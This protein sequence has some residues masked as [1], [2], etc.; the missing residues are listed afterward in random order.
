MLS[1]ESL[2]DGMLRECDICNHLFTKF[3]A[4]GFDY[5]PSPGQRDTRELLQYLSIIGIAATRCMHERNWKLFGEFST[6]SETMPPDDF[7]AAMDRQKAELA[8]FFD[9]VTEEELE[10]RLAPMPGGGE[11]PLGV[12]ILNGPFKW[13]AAYKLQLFLYAKGAGDETIGTVNAWA[14]VDM[15]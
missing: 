15:R 14:G 11:L 9:G 8:A 1:K 13:L 6:R 10:T 5:R 3:D 12:A 2:R 4:A 7:P